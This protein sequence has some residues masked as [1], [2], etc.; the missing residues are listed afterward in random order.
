MRNKV[1]GMLACAAFLLLNAYVLFVEGSIDISTVIKSTW[2]GLLGA[3]AAGII[4]YFIG[5]VIEAPPG[6]QN[7]SIEDLSNTDDDLL[8]SDM[9]IDDLKN[10]EH[11][12]L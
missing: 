3:L 9:M 6:N 4:G 10:I 12:N 2:Y 11:H 7:T 5:K 1:S 8:I